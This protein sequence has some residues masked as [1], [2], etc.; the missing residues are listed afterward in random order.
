MIS[1]TMNELIRRHEGVRASF[2][3]DSLGYW[4]IGV[5][6]LVD[7]RKGLW[8]DDELATKLQANGYRLSKNV[9]NAY[10][11]DDLMVAQTTVKELLDPVL[12]AL[13]T[14]RY[15]VLVSMAFNLGRGGFSSFKA[16]RAV[17]IA[18]D[19]QGAH[20][21]ALDSKWARQLPQRAEE[22]ATVL[23]TGD[24]TNQPR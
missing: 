21:A 23:L 15:E 11:A 14:P 3:Q 16:M 13:N 12:P 5:G 1:R 9:I 22:V 10:L 19:W 18:E 8:C 20:D 4:T 7:K 2:Y 24:A 17:I 6:H